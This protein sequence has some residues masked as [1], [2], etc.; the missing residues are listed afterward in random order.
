MDFVNLQL[1]NR[2]TVFPKLA[3][4]SVANSI[5][6]RET[7]ESTKNCRICGKAE[8]RG[9]VRPGFLIARKKRAVKTGAAWRPTLRTRQPCTRPTQH[10]TRIRHQNCKKAK[11]E[12][13]AEGEADEEVSKTKTGSDR[14]R[15]SEGHL[16]KI[17]IGAQY[18][19]CPKF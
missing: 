14:K 8:E 15:N 17:Q 12:D 6:T 2:G 1:S 11:E 16:K 13:A 9:T 3:N 4:P 7:S 19:F 10:R 5:T 18:M